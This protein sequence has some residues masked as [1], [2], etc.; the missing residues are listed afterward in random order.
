[1]YSNTAPGHASDSNPLFSFY[2]D[3]AY[4]FDFGS[5]PEDPESEDNSTEQPLSGPASRLVITSTP[6]GRFVYWPDRKPANLIDGNSRYIAYLELLPFQEGTPLARAEECTPTEVASSDSSLGHP[7]HQVFMAAGD[8]P[9]PSGTASDRYLEDISADELT[10]DAPADETDAN[11]DTRRE[12]NRKRNERHQRLRDNL[13][14]RNLAEALNQVESRVHTTPEKCLMSITAIA[15]QAQGMRAGEVIAKL[16]EDAYFMRVDNRV[17]QPPPARNRD[18]EATSRSTDLGHNRTRAELPANPNRTRATAGGPSQG[19]NSVAAA[20]S[21]R[22]IVPHRDPGGGGSDGRSSN[23]GANRRPGGGGDRGGRRHANSHASGASQGGFDARQK[24]EELRRKKSA[25]AG[26]NDSYPAFSPRLRNLLLPDK[27]KP[28][29]ITKYDAKQ[30]PIQWLRCYALSI[31]NAGGNNDT[32]CLYFPFYLDQAPL[33]WL[34]SLE[35]Y[36]IDK[37]DQL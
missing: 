12:R 26:D 8:T 13:P 5:D 22:E 36:S 32:K 9:G 29:G 33:T 31:E 15:C 24:I 18:N 17:T 2:S 23:H 27:F 20:S 34:E 3:S 10:A 4:E 16:A 35:K 7:E 37:W 6:A 28:L 21:D 19:G 1:L 14:I 25:T 11:R 30:D